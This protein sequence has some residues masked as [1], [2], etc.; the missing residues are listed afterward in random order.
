MALC[1]SQFRVHEFDEWWF[2]LVLASLVRSV[3]QAL[4]YLLRRLL[5]DAKTHNVDSLAIFSGEINVEEL[6]TEHNPFSNLMRSLVSNSV[7]LLQAFV[8]FRHDPLVTH[9]AGCYV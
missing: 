9:L 1:K 5:S 8:S 7:D 4:P 2:K 6:N 3:R